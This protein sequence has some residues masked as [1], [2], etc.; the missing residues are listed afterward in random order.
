MDSAGSL[1]SLN[2]E[3][4]EILRLFGPIVVLYIEEDGSWKVIHSVLVSILES[5]VHSASWLM[6]MLNLSVDEVP[7]LIAYRYQLYPGFTTVF[8]TSSFKLILL[9]Y[10]N[11][12]GGIVLFF[13]PLR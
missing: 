1:Q 7:N 8:K 6:L 11:L 5:K 4:V 3:E 13:L 9:D 10:D 2:T 12:N